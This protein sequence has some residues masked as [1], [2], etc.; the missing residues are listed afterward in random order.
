MWKWDQGRL[1]YSKLENTYKIASALCELDGSPLDDERDHIKALL[2]ERTGLP[3]KPEDYTAWRNYAR[4]IK[5]LGLASKIEGK[6]KTTE[7][8]RRLASNNADRITSDDYLTHI[9]KVFSYPAPCFKD[10]EPSEHKIFPIAAIIKYLLAKGEKEQYP[11]TNPQDVSSVLIG[12]N[13]TGLEPIVSYQALIKTGFRN[14][15]TG[16]RHLRELLQFIS[17]FSFLFYNNGELSCDMQAFSSFNKNDLDD[18]FK[19]IV[20]VSEKDKEL[21][22]QQ[23]FNLDVKVSLDIKN[24]STL[25]DVIFTEGKKVRANHLRTERN[26]QAIKAYFDNAKDP[27]R[28]DLCCN[29]V[30]KQY[31]WMNQL[32]EV[33]HLLPLASPLHNE[34]LGTSIADLVGLC[35]N[36]H[37]ATHSYYRKFLREN[38][39]EDFLDE[40]QAKNVYQQLKSEF[41]PL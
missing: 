10:Y 2:I 29:I 28:C 5:A 26:R 14:S 31:P 25:E 16:L 24:L 36:C 34:K 22:I 30:S 21:E 27:N 39:L 12:N 11:T 33:H 32:I 9:T 40:E 17:Q 18:L 23:L 3:F 37:R 38:E 1:Q 41:Q 6:L 7:L 13:V 19:P 20:F 35:P 8:C 15:D 4:T